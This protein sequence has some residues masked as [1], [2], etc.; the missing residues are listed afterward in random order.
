MDVVKFLVESGANVFAPNNDY[1]WVNDTSWFD[2]QNPHWKFMAYLM[3]NG[4]RSDTSKIDSEIL[5]TREN[6][7][8]L[9]AAKKGCLDIVNIL[10]DVVLIFIKTMMKYFVLALNMAFRC[11]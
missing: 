3:K 10:L 5:L 2:R 11:C 6:G 9:L 4:G 1:L 8:L 7:V